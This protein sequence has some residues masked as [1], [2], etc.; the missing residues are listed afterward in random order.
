MSFDI[1]IYSSNHRCNQEN[2]H[3]RQLQSPPALC[4]P[5]SHC[6]QT[7]VPFMLLHICAYFLELIIGG[8]T[9]YVF[10]ASFFLVTQHGYPETDPCCMY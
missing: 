9:P 8:I 5:P 10:F 3:L 4:A 1:C 6:R 2:E 7:L